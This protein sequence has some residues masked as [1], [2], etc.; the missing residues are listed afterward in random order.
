MWKV[1][2]TEDGNR[3]IPVGK[4][5]FFFIYK[6]LTS[7]GNCLSFSLLINFFP[8]TMLLCIYIRSWNPLLH[9]HNQYGYSVVGALLRIPFFICHRTNRI[10]YRY[11]F[12]II[13]GEVCRKKLYK[14]WMQGCFIVPNTCIVKLV[15]SALFLIRL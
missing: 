5:I 3:I 15:L 11:L 13:I 7:N 8:L 9:I 12:Y 1:I 6:Y 2:Y 14:L 10:M 4:N